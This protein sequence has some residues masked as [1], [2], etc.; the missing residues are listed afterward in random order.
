VASINLVVSYNIT[1]YKIIA[2]VV[3]ELFCLPF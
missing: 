2:L 1:Q 3:L